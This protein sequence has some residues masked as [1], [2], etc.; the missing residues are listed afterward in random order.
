MLSETASIEQ[1]LIPNF[2]KY[3][4]TVTQSVD[5]GSLVVAYFRYEKEK[6]SRVSEIKSVIRRITVN[7]K[8]YY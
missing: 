4:I 5:Q 2:K 8:N 1:I 6:L 7:P 3:C